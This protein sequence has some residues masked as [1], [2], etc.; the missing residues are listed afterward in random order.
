MDMRMPEMDGLEA[1]RAIRS[2]A[3]PAGRAER[4]FQQAGGSRC[5]LCRTAEAHQSEQIDKEH[6]GGTSHAGKDQTA[7]KGFYRDPQ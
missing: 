4:P 7:F 5:A 2:A 3:Q 1:T 6:Q